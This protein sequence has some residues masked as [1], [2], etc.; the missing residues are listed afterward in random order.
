MENA[1]NARP[2]IL[3]V[4]DAVFMRRQLRDYLENAGYEV[5]AEAGDGIEALDLYRT[6]RPDLVTLD[7]VMPRMTGIETLRELRA[8]HRE[9]RVIVCS[10]MSDERSIIEAV[11]LGAR[12]YVL[13]PLS[14]ET[15]L[16][17]VAKALR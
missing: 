17:A 13:K 1:P 3:V 8:H 9:A 4:D 14:C 5:V 6:H 12:D 15:L 10:S 2:R 11:R 7:V 16:E